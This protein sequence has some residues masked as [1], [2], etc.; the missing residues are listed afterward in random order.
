MTLGVVL[1]RTVPLSAFGKYAGVGVNGVTL[2]ASSS[3]V[4]SDEY[5]PTFI[6][7]KSTLSGTGCH[8]STNGTWLCGRG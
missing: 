7:T 4:R 1:M 3:T 8:A 5:V 2:G 6:A